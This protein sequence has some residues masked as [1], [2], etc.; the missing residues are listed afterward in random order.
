[1]SFK[2]AVSTLGTASGAAGALG[3]LIATQLP[4]PFSRS[5]CRTAFGFPTGNSRTPGPA[6]RSAISKTTCA[7]PTDGLRILLAEGPCGR[8]SSF[9][10][11]TTARASDSLAL[12]PAK[13]YRGNRESTDRTPSPAQKNFPTG[14]CPGRRKAVSY[15][16]Q[17]RVAPLL[18][19]PKHAAVMSVALDSRRIGRE[20]R[21]RRASCLAR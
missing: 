9:A 2:R 3:G 16:L 11:A 21:E 12:S 8:P 5:S 6:G 14:P 15:Q 4:G 20:V 18:V 13:R 19:R 7:S 10:S 17:V 1:M